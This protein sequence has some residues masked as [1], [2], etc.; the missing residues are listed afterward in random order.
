[1]GGYI[2]NYLVVVVGKVFRSREEKRGRIC[3]R[4]V[5]V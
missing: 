5:C 3:V 1:M 2:G 4:D